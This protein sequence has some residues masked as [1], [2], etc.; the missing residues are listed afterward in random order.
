[1]EMEL[2]PALQRAACAVLSQ[3]MTWACDKI[4]Y[5]Q[6]HAGCTLCPAPCR[7]PMC[8]WQGPFL[9]RLCSIPVTNVPQLLRAVG[10]HVGGPQL[11]AVSPD[12]IGTRVPSC[13]VGI[14]LGAEL[15]LSL[16][17]YCP[18]PSSCAPRSLRRTCESCCLRG[19]G[20]TGGSCLCRCSHSVRWPDTSLS[21]SLF[22]L[23]PDGAEHL[24][25]VRGPRGYPFCEVSAH[26]F[27]PFFKLGCLFLTDLYISLH[28]DG[29]S[30]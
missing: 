17:G 4:S 22:T 11:G 6:N 20:N 26:I 25:S 24:L 7:H 19:L 14:Y 18:V 23:V 30:A 3:L 27:C 13:L 1:M 8:P 21:F 5:K 28:P 9:S 10:G 16:S 2:G 29:F 12:G 15:A